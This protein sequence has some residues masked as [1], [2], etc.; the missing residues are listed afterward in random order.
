MASVFNL[1]AHLQLI[2]FIPNA[3]LQPIVFHN[4]DTQL[5]VFAPNAELQVIVF[6]PQADFPSIIF[7]TFR[8]CLSN[9]VLVVTS[10]DALIL[11]WVNVVTEL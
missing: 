7:L 3:D 5:I 11:T 2:V 9:P 1:D 8:I 6:T 10:I 4:T